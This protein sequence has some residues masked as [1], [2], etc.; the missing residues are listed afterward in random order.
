MVVTKGA[1]TGVEHFDSKAEVEK[2]I[3]T[4]PIP[5]TF[6]MPGFYMSNISGGMLR[7][8]PSSNQYV[9]ALPAPSTTPIPLF[10]ASDDTGK[11]VKAILTHKDETV[12]KRVL[13]ATDYY[14]AS[15]IVK[16]FSEVKS[17]AGKGAKFQEID[18]QTYKDSLAGFPE[19]GKEEMYQNMA[20]MNDWGYF[21]KEDLGWSHSVCSF[22]LLYQFLL[23]SPAPLSAPPTYPPTY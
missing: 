23:S 2:Y 17:E 13:A 9:F 12:G 10:D 11:F 22:P 20:F 16:I 4:L 5:A 18:K 3:R 8:D 15:D 19:R 21:G 6:F 1:F 14:T 7:L